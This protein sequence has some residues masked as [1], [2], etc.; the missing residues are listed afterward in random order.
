MFDKNFKNFPRPVISPL[1]Y[2]NRHTM[3]IP[4]SGNFQIQATNVVGG[5]DSDNMID[6]NN[7]VSIVIFEFFLQGKYTQN[8]SRKKIKNLNKPLLH[9]LDLLRNASQF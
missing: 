6:F 3:P 8:R 2:P 9:S 5:E 4:R 7:M 1:F